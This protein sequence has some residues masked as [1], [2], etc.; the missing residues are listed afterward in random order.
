MDNF[1]FDNFIIPLEDS[2]LKDFYK[3]IL[4]EAQTKVKYGE[5]EYYNYYP[6]EKK[7]IQIILETT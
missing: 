4:S 5:K 3:V 1:L 2:T 7:N 6:Q